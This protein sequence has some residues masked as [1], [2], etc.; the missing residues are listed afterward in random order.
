M[1]TVLFSKHVA[2]KASLRRQYIRSAVQRGAD[3]WSSRGQAASP[4]LGQSGVTLSSLLST[5]PGQLVREQYLRLCEQLMQ[6]LPA[7]AG[8]LGAGIAA[9]IRS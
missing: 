6:L 9:R 3:I 1:V 5:M 4:Y 2:V 8:V 7:V